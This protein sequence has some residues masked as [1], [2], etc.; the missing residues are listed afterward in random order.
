MLAEPKATERHIPPRPANYPLSDSKYRQIRTTSHKILIKGSWT[1][2]AVSELQSQYHNC[3]YTRKRTR[4]DFETPFKQPKQQQAS[5]YQHS[6]DSGF[7][8]SIGFRFLDMVWAK[9][10]ILETL[11]HPRSPTSTPQL[12]FKILPYTD[13]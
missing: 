12:P 4:T 2:L 6:E 1:G 3:F 13:Y 9:Y 5:K 7:L 10:S 11:D 8:Y